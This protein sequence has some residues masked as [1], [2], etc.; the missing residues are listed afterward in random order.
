MTAAKQVL[1]RPQADANPNPNPNPKQQKK[2][3]DISSSSVLRDELA[4]ALMA[5][6]IPNGAAVAGSLDELDGCMA[7]VDWW[8]DRRQPKT[9]GLLVHMLRTG[10]ARDYVRREGESD[11]V[12][13]V[14]GE[15]L[16]LGFSE[17]EA[18]LAASAWLTRGPTTLERMRR[19]LEVSYPWMYGEGL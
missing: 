13:R 3:V 12:A 18:P 11:R 15:M 14:V 1:A 19:H 7:T 2:T 5:R 4:N 16:A 10:Q 9:A 6:G 8:D 17:R